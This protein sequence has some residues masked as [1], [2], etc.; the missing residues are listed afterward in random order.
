MYIFIW[1]NLILQ[2]YRPGPVINVGHKIVGVQ[3]VLGEV[4]FALGQH[5]CPFLLRMDLLCSRRVEMDM[6]AQLTKRREFKRWGRLMNE[7]LQ[8]FNCFS[9]VSKWRAALPSNR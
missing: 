1:H 7:T 6:S 5:H 9:V 2:C 8:S 4:L 3:G